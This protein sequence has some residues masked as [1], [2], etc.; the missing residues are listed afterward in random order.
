MLPRVILFYA[1]QGRESIPLEEVFNKLRPLKNA[2][3]F[4]EKLSD[5]DRRHIAE[6][7]IQA[8][9]VWIEFEEGRWVLHKTHDESFDKAEEAAIEIWM[10]ADKELLE[11]LKAALVP[12]PPEKEK[13]EKDESI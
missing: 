1:L 11:G 4:K 6:A 3:A 9:N 8:D 12:A 7:S 10:A 5:I 2:E 13:E